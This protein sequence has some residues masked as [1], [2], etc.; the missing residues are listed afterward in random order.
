MKTANTSRRIFTPRKILNGVEWHTLAR[1]NQPLFRLTRILKGLEFNEML[2][3]E[4]LERFNVFRLEVV[5]SNALTSM[6]RGSI[7]LSFDTKNTFAAFGKGDE[8]FEIYFAEYQTG[9]PVKLYPE[10][11]DRATFVDKSHPYWKQRRAFFEQE[12]SN[13]IYT[14][15]QR[16]FIRD[17]IKKLKEEL[18]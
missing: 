3:R 11:L 4:E 8:R 6:K 14:D 9:F 2:S 13:P 5:I 10:G 17:E 16:A 15:N 7:S 1:A 18:K 12:L